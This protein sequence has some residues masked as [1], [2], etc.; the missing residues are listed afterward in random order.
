M[1]CVAD[2][3]LFEK[4][5]A[6]EIPADVVYEDEHCVAFRDIEP[7]APL[8]LLVVPRQ[9]IPKL[10]DAGDGDAALLGHL[11]LVA[12]KLAREAGHDAFRLVVNSGEAAGQTVFHLH[13]HVLA[14]R[15][16]T[17]PPG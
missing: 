14:G 15:P 5:I 4:I 17:W 2:S 7:Q 1:G 12:A 10:A 9:L 13:V 16:M 11:Q 8:H 6:G 3:T